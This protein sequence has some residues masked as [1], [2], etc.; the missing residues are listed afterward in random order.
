[1][2]WVVRKDYQECQNL[3]TKIEK[4]YQ[5]EE[6]PVTHTKTKTL[7]GVRY[8]CGKPNGR[9]KRKVYCQKWVRSKSHKSKAVITK[10]IHKVEHTRGTKWG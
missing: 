3:Q 4:V 10:G 5:V 2:W 6:Q 7:Y 1:M 9:T 8:G